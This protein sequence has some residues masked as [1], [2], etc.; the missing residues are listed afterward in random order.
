MQKGSINK[1]NSKCKNYFPKIVLLIFFYDF[2]KMFK[3]WHLSHIFLF[4]LLLFS[5]IVT[6]KK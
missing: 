1:S 2:I 6:F 5:D 4:S 3:N